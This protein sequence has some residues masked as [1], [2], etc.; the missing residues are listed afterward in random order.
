MRNTPTYSLLTGC[1]T[2]LFLYACN[3]GP[4]APDVS[5]IPMNVSIH[6]FDSALFTIDTNNIQP[7]LTRL[8]QSY[9][10]F[11]PVYI[12]EIMNFGAFADSSKEI[13]HQ[14]R[15]F[16][17]NRDF[18]Q[19]E[20]AV[21]QKYANTGALQKELEQAFRYTRYYIPA[22]RAPK[23]VTFTSGIANYGAITIDSIL[24]I[25][26]D[27]YMGADFPPYAQIPDYPDYMIRR[28]AP[29]YI[30]TNCMQVLQQ[31]LYPA[32]RSGGGLLEQ[33]IEAGKQQ[34][35]LSKVL[36][37]TPDSIRLGYTKEQL[38]WCRDNE[39]MIWQFFVQNNLLYTTDWQ[40]I[41]LFMNDA[42]AT[43][44]MPEGSP[45]KIGYFVGYEIVNKYMEKHADVSVQQLMES[46]N[47]LEIF[48]AS[49]Y[50]P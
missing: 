37:H 26:L 50:R 30:T 17:A 20:T 38:Q 14:L 9:P 7:G 45:G 2:A 4:K 1:L 6:R 11:M 47:L 32:P 49:K 16:L 22:F 43:Q 21:S 44:G 3:T 40:Q 27:M 31:Q 33:M 34:Y 36:P 13:Q 15:L 8:H 29:E 10:L 28:F 12:S 41:N 35:F 19:L 39:K 48:K 25:G 5:H 18:R 42:P 23:I 46:R 24:G